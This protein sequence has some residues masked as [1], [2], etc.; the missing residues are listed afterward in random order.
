M[1]GPGGKQACERGLE[2]VHGVICED[3]GALD[4]VLTLVLRLIQM[5]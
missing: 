1:L 3:E 4:L 5:L 2:A